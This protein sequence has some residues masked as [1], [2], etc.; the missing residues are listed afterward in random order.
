M[1]VF[2]ERL[3]DLRL[4][5]KISQRKLAKELGVSHSAIQRWEAALQIPNLEMSSTIA[6]YF[7]VSIDYLAGLED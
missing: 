1:K 6:Q 2:A 4:G 7:G 3:I 5:K